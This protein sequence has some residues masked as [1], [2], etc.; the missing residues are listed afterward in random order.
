MNRITTILAGLLLL[1]LSTSCEGLKMPA[2]HNASG[3]EAKVTVRPGFKFS[4]SRQLQHYPN[5]RVSD[6]TTVIL[7]PDSSMTILSIFTGLL[8][9]TKIRE[10]E[11]QT[12]Y[13]RIE[14]QTETI[15]ADSK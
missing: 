2:I 15:V 13:L 3:Q 5:G 6:S 1:L 8:F 9:N 10:R 12:N 11:L 7:Q 14:T 4:D